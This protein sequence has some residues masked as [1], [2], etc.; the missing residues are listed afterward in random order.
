MSEAL[1]GLYLS[2]LPKNPMG[3]GKITCAQLTG[4][5]SSGE[6]EVEKRLSLDF[7]KR[8]KKVI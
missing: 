7:L 4:D 5:G 1:A 3:R 8:S 6:Q 2:K